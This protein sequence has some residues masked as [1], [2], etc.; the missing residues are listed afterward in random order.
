MN[1][2]D[3]NQRRI[4]II[5]TKNHLH[6]IRDLVENVNKRVQGFELVDK[7]FPNDIRPKVKDLISVVETQL[8]T[9]LL[10]E[11]KHGKWE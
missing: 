6:E 3:D 11:M 7:S 4:D 1:D 10:L 9:F 2:M 8:A 5:H